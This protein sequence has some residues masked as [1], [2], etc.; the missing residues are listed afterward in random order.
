MAFCFFLN[1]LFW[2]SLIQSHSFSEYI[3]WWLP[4]YIYR[5]YFFS[6]TLVHPSNF[7]LNVPQVSQ[8]LCL[9]LKLQ[10]CFPS[11]FPKSVNSPIRS[12]TSPILAET[13]VTF[14]PL[15]SS[16]EPLSYQLT[17]ILLPTLSRRC[18]QHQTLDVPALPSCPNCPPASWPVCTPAFLSTGDGCAIRA[19]FLEHKPDRVTPASLSSALCL[20]SGLNQNNALRSLSAVG[21][22]G[23]C[24]KML[25]LAGCPS[26]CMHLCYFDCVFAFWFYWLQ[27]AN[28]SFHGMESYAVW[29]LVTDFHIS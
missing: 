1:M 5:S 17:H 9:K 6:F 24:T 2:Y 10:T 25:Q 23:P 12:E 28:V 4:E 21:Y 14:A 29:H 27:R 13:S 19:V 18:L 22:R 8:T 26:Q 20:R 3:F 7:H 11:L 15:S 16:P